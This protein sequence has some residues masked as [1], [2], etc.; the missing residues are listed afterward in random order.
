MASTW[1]DKKIEDSKEAYTQT[2][3]I[4][5]L[6]RPLFTSLNYPLD[7]AVYSKYDRT[8]NAVT[9]YFSPAAHKLAKVFDAKP[10]DKPSTEK[11]KLIAGDSKSTF[12]LFDDVS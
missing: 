1:F 2:T 12:V 5:G 11:L 3:R 7:M 6:F 10:C 8:T 4:Q 9:V